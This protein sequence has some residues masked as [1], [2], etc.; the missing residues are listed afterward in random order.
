MLLFHF[1]L[2]LYTWLPG[3]VQ[4]TST[5]LKACNIWRSTGDT[6]NKSPWKGIPIDPI[7]FACL[8]ELT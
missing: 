6:S 3:M 7:D 1:F 4:T 5:S 2:T 8:G